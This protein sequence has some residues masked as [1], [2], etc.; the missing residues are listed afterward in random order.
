VHSRACPSFRRQGGGA[1]ATCGT[2]RLELLKI[3]AL[4]CTRTSVRRITFAMAS[5]YPYQ[6]DFAIAH[7]Q[8]TN[9]RRADATERANSH[10]RPG[11]P[12][13][14]Y[15]VRQDS[16]SCNPPSQRR[17]RV[18]AAVPL[19]TPKLFEKSGLTSFSGATAP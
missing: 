11:R 8:L 17:R 2:I 16:P 4:V 9:G 13:R 1:K 10:T 7:A 15:C 6:R 18:A 3:G 5:G 19:Q 12:Q 14:R